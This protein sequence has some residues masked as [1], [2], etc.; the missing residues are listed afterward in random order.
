MLNHWKLYALGSAFFAGLTAV[1]AKIGVKDIP[2]NLATLVRTIVILFFLVLLVVAR[3]EWPGILSLDKKGILFLVLSG[4]AT[5]ASWL[6]YFR[7]LQGGPASVVVSI[8]KFS[9]V[10]A[11]LLSTFLLGERFSLVGWIGVVL[12]TTG[13]ITIALA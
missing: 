5:G 9:L 12:M 4:L 2:S 6:C 7:A 13:A 8:D 3:N 10:F 1:L 11:I